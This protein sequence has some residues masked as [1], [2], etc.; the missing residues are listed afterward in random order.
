VPRQQA[1][2]HFFKQPHADSPPPSVVRLGSSSVSS[3]PV[4]H[5]SAVDQPMPSVAGLGPHHRA[6]PPERCHHGV[7]C[8]VTSQ[9]CFLLKSATAPPPCPSTS[10]LAISGTDLPGLRSYRQ[11]SAR[12][13]RSLSHSWAASSGTTSPS[14]W[15]SLEKPSWAWPRST[16]SFIN[17]FS[18]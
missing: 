15:A 9:Y 10:S 1:D 17:F 16:V 6:P 18:D 11:P 14:C 2:I 4:P 5:S 3:V 7:L 13:R 8:T 12:W